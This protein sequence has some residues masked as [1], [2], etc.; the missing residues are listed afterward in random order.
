MLRWILPFWW[1]GADTRDT[2]CIVYRKSLL[3]LMLPSSSPQTFADRVA[4]LRLRTLTARKRL[5]AHLVPEHEVVF[6]DRTSLD[7]GV[8]APSP[9][10][11]SSV[12]NEL[13]LGES[14]QG[15]V[16]VDLLEIRSALVLSDGQSPHLQHLL[17]HA[18]MYPKQFKVL[19]TGRH[20]RGRSVP[21]SKVHQ[22]VA[23][24]DVAEVLDGLH[25]EMLH[26]LAA[27][28]SGD[29]FVDVQVIVLSVAAAFGAQA[30]PHVTHLVTDLLRRSRG[31]GVVAVLTATDELT[32][33]DEVLSQYVLD[34]FDVLLVNR[35]SSSP[36]SGFDG[37]VSRLLRV[38]G[39]PTHGLSRGCGL[40]RVPGRGVVEYVPYLSSMES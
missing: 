27:R 30:D 3:L 9:Q 36:E 2:P 11:L 5:A 22:A 18:A 32:W 12:W 4:H 6:K 20:Y 21:A 37:A 33:G 24:E 1:V 13:H 14:P 7:G 39:G 31:T 29:G 34:M 23:S 40:V 26:R 38:C 15:T 28:E 19:T 10:S 25:D 35:L 17:D 8:A 16:A